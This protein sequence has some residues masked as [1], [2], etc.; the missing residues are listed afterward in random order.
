MKV[1][2]KFPT[3]SRGSIFLQVFDLVIKNTIDKEN[4]KFVITADE[5]DQTMNNDSI[6][7]NLNY[8]SYNG[9][10]VTLD[11]GK[12]N[13]KIHA[14]N[15][16]IEKYT[17]WDILVLTSD[18]M[19]PVKE[20]YDDDIRIHMEKFFPDLDGVLWYKDGYTPLN[21]LPIIGRKYFERFNYIYNP[22]YESFFC[23]N[24]FHEVASMNG[25]HVALDHTILFRHDH[26]ANTGIGWDSLYE[27]NN[28]PWF[29]DQALWLK[30]KS[31][32]YK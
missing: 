23:D 8:Y 29:K 25:K 5:D 3:R 22:Q 24:E 17:E 21:T 13:N 27:R 28:S 15:R 31:E 18:D 11:I 7:F 10:D 1:L 6:R 12:S 9:Y 4:T 2:V 19:I 20:G 14:V 16:D 30:R 32:G 26:P